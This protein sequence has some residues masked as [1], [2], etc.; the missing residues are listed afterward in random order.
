[1]EL[2]NIRLLVMKL[3]SLS[4]DYRQQIKFLNRETKYKSSIALVS[5][6]AILHCVHELCYN[7]SESNSLVLNCDVRTV[8]A[9]VKSLEKS[10]LGLDLLRTKS[11]INIIDV[12]IEHQIHTSVQH[13]DSIHSEFDKLLS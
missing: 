12:I 2:L 5:L 1:M 4:D 3:R 9:S 13:I 8:F 10:V 7:I 11:V 6:K